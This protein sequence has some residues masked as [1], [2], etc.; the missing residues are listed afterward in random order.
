MSDEAM[1]NTAPVF[2]HL[3]NAPITEA[4]IDFRVRLPANFDLSRLKQAHTQIQDRYPQLDEQRII[5]EELQHT[6]GQPPKFTVRDQGIVGYFFRSE[7]QKNLAQFRRNGFTFNRLKPYTSW[8][9]VFPEACRLWQIYTTVARPEEISRI[10]VRFINRLLLPLPSLEFSDYLTAPPALPKGV[11]QSVSSFL[12]RVVIHDPETSLN[13]NVV[14]ALEP[15]LNEQYVSMILDL[16][17]YKPDVSQLTPETV[18]GHFAKLRE[19]K[20]RIFFGSLTQRAVD[21]FL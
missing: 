19:M 6:P 3:N 1:T 11:P 5:E 8:D 4:I 14:Q 16:D 21:L 9:Q 18:L 15:L 20:N 13:A 7:D 2:P 17:V 10:A 12:S